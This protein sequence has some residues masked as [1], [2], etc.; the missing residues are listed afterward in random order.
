MV[1]IGLDFEDV[2]YTDIILSPSV[3]EL[4]IINCTII[5]NVTETAFIA[6]NLKRLYIKNLTIADISIYNSDLLQFSNIDQADIE[7]INLNNTI[8]RNSSL[9]KFDNAKEF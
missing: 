4:H 8:F 1:N 7:E 9:F 5:S 6:G 3:E 2:K